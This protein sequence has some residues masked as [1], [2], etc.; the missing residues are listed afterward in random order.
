MSNREDHQTSGVGARACLGP[1]AVLG[2]AA[3]WRF[4]S[5]YSQALGGFP[6]RAPEQDSRAEKTVALTFDDGPNEPYTTQIAAFL[7][8]RLIK[9]TFFQV[10][11]CVLRYPQVTASLARAGHVIG[12]HSYSHEFTRCWTRRQLCD[13][14]QQ[15][16]DVLG[17]TLGCEPA[18]YRPPWLA[19]TPALFDILQRRSLQPV[20]GEFCHALEVFQPSAATIA[21]RAIAKVRPGAILIFHDGYDG[22]GAPRPNT[23]A[24]VKTVVDQLVAAGYGFTTVDQMLGISP[25]A[26]PGNAARS[27]TV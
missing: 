24:A 21:R 8:K 25:Y 1:G 7:D 12:N 9:A 16:Q 15:A 3:Y 23:V 26:A 4:M 13:E 14:I 18:L 10:G 19:R 17:A 2:A 5:P 22:K 11:R 20:S 6:Y 27:T